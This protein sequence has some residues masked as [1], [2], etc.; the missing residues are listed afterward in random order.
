[1]PNTSASAASSTGGHTVLTFAYENNEKDHWLTPPAL[2]KALGEFYLD[3]CANIHQ[4]WRTAKVQY[5]LPEQDGLLLP[6]SGRVFANPPYGNQTGKWVQRMALH[7]NGIMLIFARTETHDFRPIWKY[8]TAL[9][10]LYKRL[11]FHTPDGKLP[12]GGGGTAPSV[13]V[14]FGKQQVSSLA[15]LPQKG[16]AG[17]LITAWTP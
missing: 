5:A 6:W 7:N 15:S 13:L 2:L 3:P 12:K 14:A 16:F 1:M 8:A 9:L 10:F 4:P 17:A 11:K